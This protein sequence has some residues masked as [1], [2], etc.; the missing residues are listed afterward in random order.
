MAPAEAP[1]EARAARVRRPSPAKRILKGAVSGSLLA[2]VL[3]IIARRQGIDALAERARSL[4]VLPLVAAVGLQLASVG[5][6]VLRWRVL[7]R[8]Q[9]LELPLPRLARS[10][11]VGR[12]YGVFTPS[13]AGLDVYRAVDVGR[14]TGEGVRSAAAIVVEKLCGLLSLAIV[15]FLLLPFGGARW[16]GR[17][18]ILV[19]ALVGLAALAGLALLR[20]PRLFAPFVARLPSRV[21]PKVEDA[22]RTVTERPLGALDTARALALG[23]AAHVCMSSVYAATGLALGLEVGVAE[24]L[25][26][27]NA[28]IA[29]TLVPVSVAGVGVR[30]GTAVA[31]LGAVGVSPA[32]ALLVAVLG[33]LATQPPALVG[34]AIQLASATRGED[35][36]P[37]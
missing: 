13:T 10:F 15:T 26:V 3:V 36:V 35:G 25:L 4:A 33:F 16:L 28:I 24:L 22:V 23:G 7:L 2:A 20:R 12:F 17:E 11:F 31:L 21:R 9:G 19:A 1:D 34:G 14:A 18:A 6:S 37:T 5:F 8:A 30:E 27:G 29:A 32:D